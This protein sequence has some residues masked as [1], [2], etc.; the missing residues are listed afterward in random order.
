V[1]DY[2]Q[3]ELRVAA[4]VAGETIMIE[5]FRRGDDLHTAI[6]ALTLTKDPKDVTKVERTTGKAINFGFLYGQQPKGFAVY[7]RT[8]YGLN[9]TL[10]EAERFRRIFF[11]TYPALKRWHQ[12][13]FD[14]AESPAND[15]ARTIFGRLLKAQSNDSWGRFNLLTAHRV[16]GSCADLLKLAMVK[17][18]AVTPVDC[19]MIAT[20]HDE[21]VFDPPVETTAFCRE[22]VVDNMREAFVEMFGT[23]VPV[24]VEAKVSASWGEKCGPN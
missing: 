4:L 23:D 9:L 21:L 7:A 18:A 22:M 1:A 24:E 5:A 11:S 6:V 10:D 19:H 14:K 13:C 16:S 3:I 17:I 20:V 12:Q 8:T 15:S 2:S